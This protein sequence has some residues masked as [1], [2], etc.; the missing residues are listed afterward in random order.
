MTT[1]QI[2]S[3]QPAQSLVQRL[4]DEADLCRAETADDIAQLLDEAAEQL[5]ITGRQLF[6]TEGRAGALSR[7]LASSKGCVSEWVTF[8]SNVTDALGLQVMSPKAVLAEIARLRAIQ[9]P[10]GA[11]LT[12]TAAPRFVEWGAGMMVADIQ[13]DSDSTATIYAH[14]DDLGKVRAALAAQPDP[15]RAGLADLTRLDEEMRAPA[16]GDSLT[17]EQAIEFASALEVHRA[18][19]IVAD[20]AALPIGG[21]DVDMPTPLHAGYQLA[22]EEIAERI[23]TEV[24]VLPGGLT[25]P[26]CGPLPSVRQPADAAHP[27]PKG[28]APEWRGLTPDERAAFVNEICEYGTGFVAPLFSL[29]ESLEDVLKVRNSGDSQAAAPDGYK[30]LEDGKTAIPADWTPLRLEWE[31]GYPEDVAF[32]PQR[33]MDRLK[34]WLDRYFAARVA[35]AAAQAPAPAPDDKA[36]MQVL[37]ER[38]AASDYID[39]LLD[40]VLGTDRHEWTSNYGHAD[41]MAEVRERMSSLLQPMVDK[42]WGRFEA[43]VQAPAVKDHP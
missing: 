28:T 37:E 22:C 9:A 16:E 32:G 41:A 25:L 33:M 13:L 30:L 18:L 39:A 15:R 7:D 20:V 38:D 4:R 23:R 43:A 8:G 11:E 36:L 17:D 26:G 31:P 6:E 27:Q 19:R 42:A 24:H 12:W 5:Q 3:P 21:A 2:Q 29:A 34:K 1:E 14:S 40:E 10:E 35:E